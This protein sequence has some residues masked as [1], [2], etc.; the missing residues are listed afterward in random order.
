MKPTLLLFTFLL[1]LSH[2]KSPYPHLDNGMYADMETNKGTILLSLAYD[3]TPVTVANFIALT[4]GNHNQVSPEFK[5]KPYYEGI[6]FHRVIQDFM[7]QGGDPTG[8]GSGGP[9]YRFDDEI[10]DLKHDGPGILS[11]ANAGP[12]T[13]GSQFFITHKETPWL[14]GK[15]T[16]FGFVVEGQNVV[17][18]IAQ[19]DTIRKIK[20]I[21]KGKE[22][23]SFDAPKV[24]DDYLSNKEA[25]EKEAAAKA[26]AIKKEN[27]DRF[28]QLKS[29]TTNAESGLSYVITTQGSG[30]SVT[31]TNKA[32]THYAVYFTDGTL[33]DTSLSE[34][35]DRN[36][37]L[38]EAKLAA[39]KYVPILADTSPEAELI[40][41]FKEGVALLKQG[42][43]ATVFLPSNLA[44]GEKGRSGIAPNTDLIFELEIVEVIE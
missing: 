21:R 28:D 22:A 20:I 30:P 9:G 40:A 13:N 16:V 44:Y 33:L 41:G 10:T 18:S 31:T 5:G 38:N 25:K 17:D 37:M 42:D 34:V 4:E 29:Q 24:F 23:K 15:H 39:G 1:V 8:M 14:D 6:V 19:N 2:C 3:K 32:L 27:T 12:G 26:A 35:A 43:K 11:M 7:I 36:D